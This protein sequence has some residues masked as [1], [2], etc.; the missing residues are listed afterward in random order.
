MA[1]SE[2]IVYH[3]G[4]GGTSTNECDVWE[5]TKMAYMFP[6]N[7]CPSGY[8]E[9]PV[10]MNLPDNLPQTIYYQNGDI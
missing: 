3:D 10:T 9:I 8:T 4:E 5:S 7:M 6:G 2:K 1:R